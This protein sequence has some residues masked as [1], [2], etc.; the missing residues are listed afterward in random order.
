MAVAERHNLPALDELA[1][2]AGPVLQSLAPTAARQAMVFG[3]ALLHLATI[4][5]IALLFTTVKE[6]G[7]EVLLSIVTPEHRQRTQEVSALIGRRLRRFVIGEL[8]SMS[9]IGVATYIGLVLLG[10]PYP[11]LL[12]FIA[13]G[14]E[15]LPVLGPWLSA[16]PAVALALTESVEM[17]I[18][19]AIFYLVLQQ[20]E[21][22][23]IMPLVQ[24]H[25]TEMPAF[26][27]LSAVLLGGAAMGI[28]GILVA[29]PIAV[30]FHTIACE[31][32][33]PWRKRQVEMRSQLQA[34]DQHSAAAR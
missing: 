1:R 8:I 6:Q 22:N 11:L 30:V 19:V 12:A 23:V 14:L 17:A 31:V 2:F 20:V 34:A 13:F 27:V 33:I 9:I 16:V 29:L 26:L 32:L 3:G 4:F 15:L 7:R 24:R 10:V 18:A 25:Q 28:L 21:S 5:A